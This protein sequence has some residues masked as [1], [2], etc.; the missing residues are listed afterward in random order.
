MAVI[1]SVDDSAS[2]RQMLMIILQNAGHQVVSAEDGRSAFELAKLQQFDLILSDFNMP[3]LDGPGLI[4]ALRAEANYQFTP[5]LLLTTEEAAEKKQA[6]R[7]AGATGWLKKPIDGGQLLA[8]I[9][10]LLA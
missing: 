9:D 1:L 8:T 6:G 7:D 2:L 10:S 4:R 3:Q 5:M